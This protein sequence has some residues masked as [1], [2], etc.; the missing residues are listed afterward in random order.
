MFKLSNLYYMLARLQKKLILNSI[1]GCNIDKTSK[2]ESGSQVINSTLGRHSFC[3]Y[4]CSIIN[5]DVGSF[6]SI[7]QNVI[8]GGPRHPME[9]VST[10]PAFLSHRDSIKTKFA[11]HHYYHQPRT[12]IGNDVW[13]GYGAMIKSGVKVGHGA[14]VGM[15]AI[16]TR[17][18]PPY[19]IV[20]GNPARVI[21][22]RFVPEIRDRL[23]ESQWWNMSD[24]DL[25][26]Y[27]AVFNDPKRFLE[28]ISGG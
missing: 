9:F 3:G 23:L 15:G 27:G 5:A 25:Q 7:A 11:R 2:I 13:I 4:N 16:V 28:A 14:V 1:R 24:D 20:A 22:E 17:D 10:S 8:V 6:C 26:R 19:A 18:V 21:R 12:E